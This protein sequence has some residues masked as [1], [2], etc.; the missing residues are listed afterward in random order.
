MKPFD[1]WRLPAKTRAEAYV[2]ELTIEEKIAQLFISDWRMGK[3]PVSYTHLDVYK[4]QLQGKMEVRKVGIFIQ[5]LSVI[6]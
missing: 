3:Y 5:L 4:R 2:K 1:D 6:L